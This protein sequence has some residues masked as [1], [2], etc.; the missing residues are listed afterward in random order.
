MHHW[1]RNTAGKL[2]RTSAPQEQGC[3]VSLHNQM[4]PP[5]EEKQ[6]Q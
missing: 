1:D 6:S 2:E 4:E 5:P 3:E